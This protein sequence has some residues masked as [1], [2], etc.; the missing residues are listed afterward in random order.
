MTIT[1][2]EQKYIFKFDLSLCCHIGP[3][4]STRMP[5]SG[6]MQAQGYIAVHLYIIYCHFVAILAL[7][8]VPGSLT[9]EPCKQ[10]A[11]LLQLRA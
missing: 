8:K 5:N 9:Q 10:R 3:T 7:P 11:Y 4:Q 6:A 2:K 1:V